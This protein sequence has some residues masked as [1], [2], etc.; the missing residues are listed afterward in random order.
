MSSPAD[1]GIEGRFA[2]GGVMVTTITARSKGRPRGFDRNLALHKALEVFWQRGFDPTTVGD[3][4]AAM[5]INPPSL[6]AAFGN[7]SALFMEAVSRYEA[8]YWEPAWRRF[9]EG[10]HLYAAMECFLLETAQ[11]LSSQDAP[12]GC[13][14][15]LAAT[16]VSDESAEVYRAMKMRR[17][18]TRQHFLRRMKRA[19]ADGELQPNADIDIQAA[20]FTTVLQGMSVQAKDGASRD[21]LESIAKGSL[22]L[23]SL[24]IMQTTVTAPS[25]LLPLNSRTGS[26]C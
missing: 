26:G 15:V 19:L 23:L 12:C 5:E 13:I 8:T 24:L 9:D 6:Y 20:L 16:N 11:I 14:V 21:T 25:V 10:Q 7:K 3:L 1:G 17:D 22:A 18:E 4:C 2:E